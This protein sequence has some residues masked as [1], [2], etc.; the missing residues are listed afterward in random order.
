MLL[1]G[2]A[3]TLLLAGIEVAVGLAAG[4]LALVS[5]AGHMLVDSAGLLLALLAALV[6]R[7]PADFRRTYGYVR[8]EI[9][10]VPVHVVL[11]AG[12]A[13]FIVYESV[14]RFGSP[15]DVEAGPVL[16][17]GLVGL[18]V[19]VLVL[20]LLHR[21]Q[22]HSLNVRAAWL[23]VAA[24][25]AGSAGVIVAALV[26]MVTGWSVADLVAS[27]AIAAF[28][29]PRA[30][31]LLR[32]A[33]SV[34]LETAPRGID[35]SAIEVDAR[36]VPGVRALHD[37]HVWALTPAF[38]ALSAHVEVDRMEGSDRI[39]AGLAGMLRERHGIA[40]V[41]LQPETPDLHDAI[42]CCLYPD[43]LPGEHIHA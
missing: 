13:A 7:R 12:V 41:T 19:N 18:A 29:L 38:V 40:H 37:L 25:T 9:L 43:Q 27:L 24:D 22:E 23:E 16:A 31:A 6:A 1:L 11:M 35:T 5:D 8:A 36:S 10:V 21:H 14:R 17:V 20:R 4:S 26:V 34:L 2:L 33:V 30:A 28:I 3:L 42:V 15:V 39:L 32:Q